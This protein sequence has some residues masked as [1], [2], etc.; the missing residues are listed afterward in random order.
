[1]F[2]YSKNNKISNFFKGKKDINPTRYVLSGPVTVLVTHTRCSQE[3]TQSLLTRLYL[4]R[5]HGFQ[6]KIFSQRQ[7]Q[8]PQQV[9]SVGCD[10]SWDAV[11]ERD[12]DHFLSKSDC[13]ADSHEK[14]PQP[15]KQVSALCHSAACGLWLPSLGAQPSDTDPCGKKAPGL[16]HTITIWASWKQLR[17]RQGH[18]LSTG[19]PSPQTLNTTWPPVP[20]RRHLA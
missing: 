7:H 14:R 10:R 5:T 19:T 18:L 15:D 17:E 16:W 13:L 6:V 2:Y 11:S 20:G 8:E 1:M 4:E 9:A 3:I 12:E